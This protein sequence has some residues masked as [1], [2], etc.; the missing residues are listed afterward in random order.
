MVVNIERLFAKRAN[1]LRSS[2]IRELLKI[3][4][5]PGMISFAG[6]LPNPKAFPVEVIKNCVNDILENYPHKAL[7][8]GSTEGSTQLRGLL[9]ERMKNLKNINCQLHDIVIT[10][11]AQQALSLVALCF[12]DPGNQYQWIM[13]VL[14]LIL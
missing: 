10:T 3:T 5:I 6:G 13:K 1:R 2:E 14:I 7:Q 11:G 12:L 4:K 9:A 8:Y